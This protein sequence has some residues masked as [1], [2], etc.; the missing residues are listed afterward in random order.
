[1][2]K[3]LF[4]MLV[5]GF[6]GALLAH[7]KKLHNVAGMRRDDWSIT[8]RAGWLDDTVFARAIRRRSARFS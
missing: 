1:M 5:L 6:F 3:D 7:G 2:P 8:L 4:D